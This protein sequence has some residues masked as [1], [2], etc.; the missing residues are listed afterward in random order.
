M[1][2]AQF[3]A[4]RKIMQTAT[5]LK[6]MIAKYKAD[7]VKYTGLLDYNEKQGKSIEGVKRTLNKCIE[8]LDYYRKKFHDLRLPDHNIKNQVIESV[9]CEGC[10]ARIAK[11]NTYC[12]ECLCED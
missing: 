9:Q 3:Q 6:G 10:G 5:G 7:V 1:T 12:G 2:E 4:A 11:G 8:R